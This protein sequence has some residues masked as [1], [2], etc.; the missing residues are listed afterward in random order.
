MF[1][2]TKLKKKNERDIEK[3]EDLID[4]LIETLE[5]LI[6]NKNKEL[7]LSQKINKQKKGTYEELAEKIN[8]F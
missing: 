1:L 6:N 3:L 7:L 4:N 2:K 5:N 8:Q